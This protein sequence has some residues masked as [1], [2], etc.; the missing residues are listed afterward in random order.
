MWQF[1][2]NVVMMNGIVMSSNQGLLKKTSFDRELLVRCTFYTESIHF[3]LTIPVLF[4]MM[5]FYRQ[6]PDWSTI[7]P[8]IIVCLLSPASTWAMKVS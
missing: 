8:N 6:M 1:F 4:G 5:A 3:L 2:G 7:L